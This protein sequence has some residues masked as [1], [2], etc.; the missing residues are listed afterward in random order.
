MNTLTKQI[1]I[2]L[3]L[4]TQTLI[5]FSNLHAQCNNS[6]LKTPKEFV[7]NRLEGDNKIYGHP[8]TMFNKRYSNFNIKN[9][10][11][12]ICKNIQFDNKI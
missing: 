10:I 3:I 5:V 2:L 4:F 7:K 11:D 9:E 1:I 6:F 12:T 8:Y